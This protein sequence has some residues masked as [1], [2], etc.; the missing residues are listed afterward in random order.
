VSPKSYQTTNNGW[1]L[2]YKTGTSVPK[3]RGVN[4]IITTFGDFD[5]I[6]LGKRCKRFWG[7]VANIFAQNGYIQNNF[8]IYTGLCYEQD[9]VK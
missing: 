4:V 3:S 5:Y 9:M 8:K 1:K 7:N 6:L 2:F